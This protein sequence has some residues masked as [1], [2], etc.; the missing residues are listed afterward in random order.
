MVSP[1]TGVL[2]GS[3]NTEPSVHCQ[4]QYRP[5][6]GELH[7]AAQFGLPSSAARPGVHDDLYKP[8][9]TSCEPVIVACAHANSTN[10][11][12]DHN[13]APGVSAAHAAIAWGCV[14]ALDTTWRHLFT[15]ASR[16]YP[17]GHSWHC[18]EPTGEAHGEGVE[19]TVADAE[20]EVDAQ[21][22]VD[23]VA[24]IDGSIVPYTEL[25]GDAVGS[26]VLSIELTLAE[27]TRILLLPV[28]AT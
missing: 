25:R 10:E 16:V 6:A 11:S 1:E 28:S 8:V 5:E 24:H 20:T 18:G 17:V 2:S 3:P 4:A 21:A 9:Q 22:D 12:M 23:A 27:I 15:D 19:D 26:A 7:T 14:A 13:V